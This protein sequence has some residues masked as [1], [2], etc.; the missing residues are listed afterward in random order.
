VRIHRIR[1]RNFRGVADGRIDLAPKGV[2]VVEGRNEAGKSS[3]LEAF[4]LLFRELD[5]THKREVLDV[6]P[7]DR[8]IGTEI[9]A[10]VETGPYRFT[11]MKRFFRSPATELRVTAPRPEQH[12]GRLAHER[13]LR[14]LEETM[15]LDLFEALSVTQGGA[16]DQADLHKSKS[17]VQALDE[18]AGRAASGDREIALFDAVRQEY[19]LHFTPER[20][21]PRKPLRDAK[22]AE[23]AAEARVADLEEQL[24][25]LEADIERSAQLHREILETA[26]AETKAKT[27]LERREREALDLEKRERAA[28]GTKT[29][30][31]LKETTAVFARKN[32]ADRQALAARA[33]EAADRRA[34]VEADAAKARPKLLEAEEAARKAEAHRVASETQAR[35]A[36]TVYRL[37]HGDF[38]YED[39]RLQRELLAERRGR[40]VEAR[41]AAAASRVALKEIRVTDAVV[42]KLHQTHLRHETASARVDAERPQVTVRALQ[43]LAAEI[44][45]KPRPLAKDET[46]ETRVAG[47]TTVLVPGV[48]EVTVRA[49]KDVTESLVSARLELRRLLADANVESLEAAAAANERR[50]DAERTLRDAERIEREN[51]RDLTLELVDEKMERLRA[52]VEAYPSERPPGPPLASGFEPANEAKNVAERLHQEATAE[53]DLARTRALETA[54]RAE[55]L[56]SEMAETVVQVRVAAE[57]EL[58]AR[59]EWEGARGTEAELADAAAKAEDDL[60]EA[61]AAHDAERAALAAADPQRVRG[62]AHNARAAVSD[63]AH[64]LRAAQDE[65]I[66][67]TAR[68]EK[69]NERGLFEQLQEGKTA[70]QHACRERRQLEREA[71]AAKLLCDTMR[72]KR[73]EARRAYAAP[74]RGK[75]VELG[76]VVFGETFTV[77][78]DDD[79]RI[80]R[81]TLD[82]KTLPF[83]SLSVGAREQLALL[84]RLACALLVDPSEGVPLLFDDTLGHSDPSRLVAM[85]EVLAL[86]GDRCQVVVLTCTPDRFGA[87]PGARVVRLGA[88]EPAPNRIAGAFTSPPQ[89]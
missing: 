61:K 87:V 55:Q 63:A 77:E 40:V 8:D 80:D 29:K 59:R 53:L 24:H 1:V 34:R 9:E 31:T 66:A 3:F 35:D 49:A 7:V 51:L 25:A 18:A 23:E 89:A 22:R 88:A 32:L 11:Y 27:D 38:K 6:R 70:R 48:V 75:I 33:R 39:A 79:L 45:G 69:G 37:R 30:L 44:D 85:R 20:G 21:E 50:K 5:S 58:R 71:A 78:L 68:L 47:E 81:R 26:A 64:R 4:R 42:A 15:D 65:M 74:L 12:T 52:W 17:F 54:G 86:A 28:E 62:A 72:E 83:R 67:V 57:A 46:L 2:T 84:A 16:P 73:E 76:R 82:G 13:A 41:R 19:E 36:L 10:D 43:P 56:K 60:R 14:L